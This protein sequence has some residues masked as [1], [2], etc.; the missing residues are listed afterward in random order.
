VSEAGCG[1]RATPHFK[2]CSSG[3]TPELGLCWRVAT[4]THTGHTASNA[5]DATWYFR[6]PQLP[7]PKGHGPS[8]GPK[9][10]VKGMLSSWSTENSTRDSSAFQMGGGEGGCLA[11]YPS[12]TRLGRL[13][14]TWVQPNSREKREHARAHAR[15]LRFPVFLLQ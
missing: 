13:K 3:L 5:M 2:P 7:P 14:C 9:P 11:C 1:A 12:G 15:R 8:H 10:R 4:H 6:G